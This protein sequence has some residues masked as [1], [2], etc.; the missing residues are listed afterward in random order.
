MFVKQEK[1]KEVNHS[2]FFRFLSKSYQERFFLV[3]V[4]VSTMKKFIFW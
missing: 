1:R 3:C 4:Y 2:I